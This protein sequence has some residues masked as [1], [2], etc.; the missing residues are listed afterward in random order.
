MP[1]S[2][3]EK[4]EIL[5][6]TTHLFQTFV[7]SVNCTALTELEISNGFLAEVPD[8][9]KNLQLSLADFSKNVLSSF[10]FEQLPWSGNLATINLRDNHFAA[11]PMIDNMN[12][13]Y[14]ATHLVV[15][16]NFPFHI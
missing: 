16:V 10:T 3:C 13:N 11:L 2:C 14:L 4:L 5:K 6:F 1:L 8:L 15:G 9:S 12:W 7:F